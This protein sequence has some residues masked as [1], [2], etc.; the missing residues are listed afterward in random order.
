MRTGAAGWIIGGV[1]FALLAGGVFYYRS[2]AADYQAR[3]REATRRA[4]DLDARLRQA[5]AARPAAPAPDAAFVPPATAA[6]AA[7]DPRVAELEA[8]LAERDRMIARFRTDAT[9]RPERGPGAWRNPQEWMENLRR[10]DPARYEEMVRRR[11]EMRR[12]MD[13]AFAQR[14]AFFLGRDTSKMTKEE[15]A[16][17]EALVQ[18]LDETWQLSAALR[19]PAATGDQRRETAQTLRQNVEK[20]GPLMDEARDQEFYRIGRSVGYNDRDAAAFVDYLHTVLDATSARRIFPDGG[21]GRGG[22]R[23]DAPRGAGP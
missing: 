12:R 17:H 8:Q 6:P 2:A 22:P 4:D 5:R 23:N 14:A 13:A 1:A 7:S 20:L 21:R 16:G 3:W 19:D 15:K 10:E 9:N 18:L 11:E